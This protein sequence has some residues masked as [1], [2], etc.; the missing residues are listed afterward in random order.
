MFGLPMPKPDRYG[1]KRQKSVQQEKQPRPKSKVLK[2]LSEFL[3]RR[4]PWL[5]RAYAIEGLILRGWRHPLAITLATHRVKRTI[6]PSFPLWTPR[7]ST[8]ALTLTDWF[9]ILFRSLRAFVFFRMLA[10]RPRDPR[11][12]LHSTDLCIID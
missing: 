8:V 3:E 4:A 11:K 1:W 5:A 10:A 7:D 6:F 9:A 12:L 2:K